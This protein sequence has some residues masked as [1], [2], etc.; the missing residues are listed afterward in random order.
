MEARRRVALWYHNVTSKL[1]ASQ[2]L[3]SAKG[4][5]VGITRYGDL[6]SDSPVCLQYRQI[7][8]KDR[9]ASGLDSEPNVHDR[10]WQY[11]LRYHFCRRYGAFKFYSISI[12]VVLTTWIGSGGATAC[13]TAGR[14]AEAD[15]SLKILVRVSKESL[16][17]QYFSDS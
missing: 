9:S 10:L 16:V 17:L 2:I 14:L 11:S 15:P 4:N 7:T 5:S 8:F 6:N 1:R 12:A 3:C 13:V